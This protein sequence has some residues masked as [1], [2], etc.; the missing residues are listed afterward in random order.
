MPGM[1]NI[2]SRNKTVRIFIICIKKKFKEEEGG[3]RNNNLLV[4]IIE[5]KYKL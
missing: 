5:P 4:T 1:K 3:Q 2:S